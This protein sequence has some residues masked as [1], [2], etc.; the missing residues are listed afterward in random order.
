MAIAFARSLTVLKLKI[1]KLRV[2]SL[3]RPSVRP[4][5]PKLDFEYCGNLLDDQVVLDEA[6]IGQIFIYNFDQRLDSL[7]F[8]LERLVDLVEVVRVVELFDGR[9]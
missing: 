1:L 4:F 6:K 9:R 3:V 7:L 8:L 5:G 2:R